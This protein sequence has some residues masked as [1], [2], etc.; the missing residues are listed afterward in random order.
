[1]GHSRPPT[2]REFLASGVRVVAGATLLASCSGTPGADQTGAAPRPSSL[3]T[4]GRTGLSLPVVSIGTAYAMNLVDRALADGMRYIHT[5]STYTEH[6]HER[7]LGQALR[8]WPR[9][10]FVLG[11]SPDLPYR[12]SGGGLS[13]DVGVGLDPGLIATSMRESLTRLGLDHV[14][15]YY[16]ASVNQRRSVL[17]EPYIRAFERLK[18]EGLTRFTGIVTH[19]NEPEVIRAAA[20]SGA[21]DVVVT[22]YNFRQSH[23]E[24]VA[25]AIG[26]AAAAG[27]GVI[28][29]KTQAGVYWDRFRLRKINMKA[30][31][32]WVVQDEH[33]HT[34]IP[35]FSN[36]DELREDL[37]VIADPRL[38]PA[39]RA[40]LRLG[41]SAGLTG[42]FCQQC[43][44]CLPQ[45]PSG[46]NVRA[47]MRAS[48][49]A[50]GYGDTGKAVRLLRASGATGE[51]CGACARCRVGCALGLDVQA[52]AL[53]LVTLMRA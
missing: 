20:E 47:L 14:D 22:A 24:E 11:T 3:R 37:E 17:H 50:A 2:R 5:S 9:D 44:A 33:V 10:S 1:M 36:F 51:A 29:M 12:F 18:E 38:T 28:A 15:I 19:A 42:V 32:K 45:C 21:W 23:R 31:L 13:D 43:G 41:E 26:E 16:L 39:E 48:M 25:D 6:N 53:D 40:D 35:A 8:K 46:V 7:L 4:L 30:A 52:S 34:T 49:Y 27:L